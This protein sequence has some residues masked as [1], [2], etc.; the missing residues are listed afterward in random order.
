MTDLIKLYGERNTN[1]NYMS[2][3][4]ALNLCSKEVPGMVP[5]W[6]RKIQ[7]RSP[8]NE[9][10]RDLYFNLTYGKNLG[11]KH[12]LAKPWSEIQKCRIAQSNLFFLTLT[13]NPYSWLLS[14]YRNPY[15]QHDSEMLD[16]ETF[17]RSPWRTVGRE[18]AGAVLSNPIKLWN[19]K[20]KSYLQLDP[21]QTL[22]LTSESV[23]ENPEGSIR[24]VSEK[25]SIVR[26]SDKFIDY[27]S[28]TKGENKDSAYYRDYYLSERWRENLS[29]EAIEI[30]NQSVNQQ[31]MAHF[32]Y[33]VLAKN[34]GGAG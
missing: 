7:D 31:L 28:S 6:L 3:L 13:K 9:W 14:L 16:F 2:K 21:K 32:G 15:H 4:L 12:S 22:N 29:Q 11:W 26:K 1:T 33:R 18:N 23:F 27:Q 17:L 8:G 34:E 19:I 24:K 20:N 30:I 25:F 10:I 5:I